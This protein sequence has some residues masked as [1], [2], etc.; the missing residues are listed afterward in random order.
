MESR[1]RCLR[2]DRSGVTA[3]EYALIAGI[4]AVVIIAAMNVFSPQ[5][6]SLFSNTTNTFTNA[7]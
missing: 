1:A 6:N 5:I 3:L 2:G 7:G 4:M